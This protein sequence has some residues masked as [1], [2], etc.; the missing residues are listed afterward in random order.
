MAEV[1]KIILR[2]EDV[3]DSINSP[4]SKIK[5]YSFQ[6]N[7]EVDEIIDDREKEKD[8]FVMKLTEKIKK[9]TL[10][11]SKLLGYIGLALGIVI[12]VTMMFLYPIGFATYYDDANMYRYGYA[13]LVMLPYLIGA[14]T[15]FICLLLCKERKKMFIFRLAFIVSLTSVLICLFIPLWC[16][17][18]A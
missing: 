2:S 5:D 11:Q 9:Q 8:T 6:T 1:E 4:K 14:I 10:D 17:I 7:E 13:F 3:E 16:L 15:G 18:I 12:T